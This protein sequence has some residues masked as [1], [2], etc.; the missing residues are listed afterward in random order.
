M[1]SME[2]RRNALLANAASAAATA[3]RAL[4]LG[5]DFAE[6]IGAAVADTLAEDW[7]GQTIYFPQD[8]SFKLS[9]REREILDA[10]RNGATVP[11]LA[12][13][14]RMSEQGIRKLLTRANFR[15][16]NLNQMSLFR[17]AP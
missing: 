12:K 16:R 10:H 11:G 3:A 5:D 17:T 14:Y 7:G 15:D 13:R 2:A 8:A 6:Q 4:G 1:K 9:P